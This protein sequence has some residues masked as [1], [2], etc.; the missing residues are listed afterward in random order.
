MA[1]PQ[2]TQQPASVG[3]TRAGR[4]RTLK[5]AVIG[6][7]IGAVL[8]ALGFVVTY[9]W[10]ISALDNRSAELEATYGEGYGVSEATSH[11]EVALYVG[12]AAV[13]AV[14]EIIL[15]ITMAATNQQGCPWARIVATALGGAS[16]L[17]AAGNVALSAFQDNIFAIPVTYTVIDQAIAITIV[18]LLWQPD[19]SSYFRTKSIK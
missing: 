4:P 2:Y 8:A 18:V 12:F 9:L 15:W 6:M 19:S 13:M 14:V 5:L 11:G 17:L 3:L 16:V 1:D 10:T 7:W